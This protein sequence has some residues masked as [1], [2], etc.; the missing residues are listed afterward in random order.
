ML[1]FAVMI[2]HLKAGDSAPDF[3][4]LDED[5]K[6]I[7]LSDYSG[8]RLVLYFYPH[9]LTPTC[10]VQACNLRDNMSSLKEHG[11][12]IIGVSEDDGKKHQKFIAKH[13][14]SFPLIADT[15]H[16]VLKAYGVWG[17][18]KFMGREFTGTHRTTFLINEEGKIHDVIKKV[19]SKEHS[20]QIIESFTN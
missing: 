18:K 8:E 10:T 15:N 3:Q 13:K 5:G 7:S 11:I 9:D 6:P 19:K 12:K 1:I 16:E 2:T 20:L 4:G 14:L 17:P